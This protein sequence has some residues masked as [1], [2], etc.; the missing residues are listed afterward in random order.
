LFKKTIIE[1]GFF[2]GLYKGVTPPLFGMGIINMVMFGL[3]GMSRDFLSILY[4]NKDTSQLTLKHTFIAGFISGVGVSFVVTPIEQIKARLQ[5]Q[6]SIPGAIQTYSGPI[7]CCKKLIK[8][9]GIIHGMYNG[10]LSTVMTRWNCWAYFGGYEVGRNYFL[11]KNGKITNFEQF[12][13]G[14]FAGT[15]YWMIALPFD[16]VKNRMMSQPDVKP[17]KYPTVWSCWKIIWKVDGLKGFFKGFTP[18]L[19]R[20]FPANGST[21]LA[22]KITN[23]FLSYF[24]KILGYK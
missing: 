10:F 18:C 4:T 6:Y 24:D 16:T 21:F 22:L 7:D 19:L 12:L 1:E 13:V 3:Y 15:T 11:K 23:E 5:V 20:T 2:K 8:N 14:G 9:N 17:R